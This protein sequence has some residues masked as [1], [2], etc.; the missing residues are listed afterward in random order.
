MSFPSTCIHAQ[1]FSCVQLRVTLWTIACQ[2][3]L[4][5]VFPSRKYWSVLPFPTLGNLPNPGVKPAFL[6]SPKL[7]DSLPLHPLGSPFPHF[8]SA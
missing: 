7:A 6:E 8:T 2:I 4:P 3:P 1:L 5:I